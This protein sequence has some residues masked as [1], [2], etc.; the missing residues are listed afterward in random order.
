VS[1]HQRWVEMA[2]V[3]TTWALRF[4]GWFHRHFGRGPSLVLVALSAGYF[5]LRNGAA[6]RASAAY[7]RH[8][9]AAAGGPGASRLR[10][11]GWAM[12]H[13]YEIALCV[14]D[15][16]VVWGGGIDTFT[17]E[18]DGSGRI[19]DLAKTGRGGLL[20]GAHLGNLDM[21]GFIARSHD[22]RVNVVAFFANAERINSFLESFGGDRLRLIHLEPG[23]LNAALDI[24]AAIDRGEFV[25]VMADRRSPGS[26]ER[27]AQV[28]FLGSEARF[29]LGPFRLAATLG[30]PVYFAACVRT[31]NARY[32]TI[33]RPIGSGRRVERGRRDERA[34]ELLARYVALLEEMCLR[35]PLQWFN[36]FD[37]WEEEGR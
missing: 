25:A 8:L 37:F 36:F 11:V 3:G 15:R 24:R 1:G 10:R 29:P 14:Y 34:H 16:I 27:D 21:L 32:T 30:C 6:R 22:L 26:S 31:A 33:M 4:A 17:L 5:W 7:L 35:Y 18:H 2:E 12:R 23:S 28:K 13:F 20:L 9:E 19:F